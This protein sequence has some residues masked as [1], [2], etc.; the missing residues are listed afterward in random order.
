M[1]RTRRF[2]FT[3]ALLSLLTAPALSA[4]TYG[5]GVSLE[6]TTPIGEILAEPEAWAGKVVRVEGEITGVCAMKGC[7][8]ELENAEGERL[9]IKVEDDVLVFP[10][11]AQGANAIAQGKVEVREMTREQW[12]GWQRHLAEEQGQSFDEASLGDGPYRLVQIRGIG[13]EI[14]ED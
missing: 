5:D 7:W 10:S 4:T 13:A 1:T 14:S 3:L 11:E 9:R 6:D 12:V 8:M 2:C